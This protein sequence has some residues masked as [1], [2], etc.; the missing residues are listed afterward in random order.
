VISDSALSDGV[1]CGILGRSEKE[2]EEL[3]DC[4]SYDDDETETPLV[5]GF[6]AAGCRCVGILTDKDGVERDVTFTRR[7]PQ[8][9]ADAVKF[10]LSEEVV[11][12][13]STAFRGCGA[14]T[15][16]SIHTGV[17]SIAPGALAE[18]PLERVAFYDI[19]GATRAGYE[20]CGDLVMEW[21]AREVRPQITGDPAVL[22][23]LRTVQ[24]L[25]TLKQPNCDA[26]RLPWAVEQMAGGVRV[27]PIVRYTA[28]EMEWA[29]V[30]SPF[31]ALWLAENSAE[32]DDDDDDDDEQ[33][34]RLRGL[35]LRDPG[36][37]E[38]DPARLAVLDGDR[39]HLADAE[40]PLNIRLVIGAAA[41]RSDD[42]VIGAF[43]DKWP[44]LVPL[45]CEAVARHGKNTHLLALHREQAK[46]PAVFMNALL[47]GN[48]HGVRTLLQMGIPPPDGSAVAVCFADNAKALAVLREQPG[49]TVD[50]SERMIL[51]FDAVRCARLL[52]L[53]AHDLLEAGIE[54]R[55]IFTIANWLCAGMISVD[56]V[57]SHA[58]RLGSGAVARLA[59]AAGANV[60]FDMAVKCESPEIRR[61]LMGPVMFGMPSLDPPQFATLRVAESDRR[62]LLNASWASQCRQICG[63]VVRAQIEDAVVAGQLAVSDEFTIQG[64]RFLALIGQDNTRLLHWFGDRTTRQGLEETLLGFVVQLLLK[65]QLRRIMRDNRFRY[66]PKFVGFLEDRRMCI[67]AEPANANDLAAPIESVAEL[68][69]MTVERRVLSKWDLLRRVW[70]IIASADVA[71]WFNCF[72]KIPQA[73]CLAAGGSAIGLVGNGVW[74]G[75]VYFSKSDS[76]HIT[77]EQEYRAHT[78]VQMGATQTAAAHAIGL[79]PQSVRSMIA[80][81]ECGPGRSIA[82]CLEDATVLALGPGT[83]RPLLC[84]TDGIGHIDFIGAGQ[85]ATW[86][87]LARRSFDHI[88]KKGFPGVIIGRCNDRVIVSVAPGVGTF[89]FEIP[90]SLLIGVGVTIPRLSRMAEDDTRHVVQINTAESWVVEW[91]R[92]LTVGES[93]KLLEWTE[94]F[95]SAIGNSVVCTIVGAVAT[96]ARTGPPMQVMLNHP[97]GFGV[98][99]MSGVQP[100]SGPRFK[101]AGDAY[102][103]NAPGGWRLAEKVAAGRGMM[104]ASDLRSRAVQFGLAW[105][106]APTLRRVAWTLFLYWAAGEMFQSA[107]EFSFPAGVQHNSATRYFERALAVGLPRAPGVESRMIQPPWAE[108][109]RQCVQTLLRAGC[110]A[111]WPEMIEVVDEHSAK[112]EDET[113]RERFVYVAQAILMQRLR[114]RGDGEGRDSVRAELRAEEVDIG[115][116][117]RELCRIITDVQRQLRV[118]HF[119]GSNPEDS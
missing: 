24:I 67:I 19:P 57:I 49:V 68:V 89:R 78:L 110:F 18:C 59:I 44:H 55:A 90:R 33:I 8:V 72:E 94:P 34:Q 115:I 51:K 28:K 20:A 5:M 98:A 38:V 101:V 40:M 10:V 85:L 118:S 92:N 64:Q 105:P 48:E 3:F 37:E 108:V 2:L 53:S 104:A 96:F 100:G 81:R 21:A 46:A 84:Y 74:D 114:E 4:P 56:E 32:Q 1:S 75:D 86:P 50:L 58:M 112:I 43:L 80:Q 107:L 15:E 26:A 119:T 65:S 63:R 93:P 23:E 54:H 22:T 25:K 70:S 41:Q 39:R 83:N 66:R 42:E 82:A 77:E 45:A 9:P 61:M 31:S 52:E 6:R 69:A 95:V 17:S 87:R 97:S 88:V 60:S 106:K 102:L 103:L 113:E 12:I 117:N 76:M 29:I 71:R 47:S 27:N 111:G 91:L 13:T 99:N 11:E 35:V 73:I 79:F 7:R 62:N 30:R 109:R 14:L 36:N 16:L 116:N